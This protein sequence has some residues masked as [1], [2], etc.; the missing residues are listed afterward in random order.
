MTRDGRA[1][2]ANDM[3]LPLAVPNIWYRV[4]WTAGELSFAGLTMPGTPLLIAG[5]RV[6]AGADLGTRSTFADLGAT[7]AEMFSVRAPRHGAS[8]LQEI[9]A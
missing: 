4:Q 1:I 5:P 7:L 2:L 9:R 6:R 3:H 8:F